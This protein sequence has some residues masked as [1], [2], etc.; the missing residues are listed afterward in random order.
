MLSLDN[1]THIRWE[2]VH[3]ALRSEI[4]NVKER[5]KSTD[6]TVLEVD[7]ANVR[8]DEELFRKISATL[9]FPEYFGSNWDAMDECLADLQWSPVSGCALFIFGADMLWK[10]ATFTAGRF[11]SAWLT[12][13]EHWGQN[14]ISFHLV[15]VLPD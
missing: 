15:F 14:E 2:C 13:A 5:L 6:I 11:V 1:L 12:A 7:C 10:N 8:S 9:K 4:A 3:Y